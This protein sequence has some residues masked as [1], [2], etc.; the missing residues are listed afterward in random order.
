V[1]Q[2]EAEEVDLLPDTAD[3][4]HRLAE[5][6]LRVAGRVGERHEHLPHPLPPLA[7]VAVHGRAAA[8]KAALS[9]QA[10]E[11]PLGRVPLLGR[12]CAV[13]RQDRGERRE[14]RT[15]GRLPTPVARRYG[16]AQH[17]AHRVAVDAE[18]P[19]LPRLVPHERRQGQRRRT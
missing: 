4:R 2:V 10:L 14:L 16:K 18:H 1:R 3:R 17:L 11:N 5:I 13:R 8:G 7:D 6:R 9:A 12:G 19:R 15:C